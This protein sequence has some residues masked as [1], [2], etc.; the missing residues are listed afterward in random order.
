MPHTSQYYNITNS[1]GDFAPFNDATARA[2]GWEYYYDDPNGLSTKLGSIRHRDEGGVDILDGTF[3]IDAFVNPDLEHLNFNSV[4]DFRHGVKQV[5]ILNG[6]SIDAGKVYA[7]AVNAEAVAGYDAESGTLTATL[8]DGSGTP[9]VGGTLTGTLDTWNGLAGLTLS[10]DMLNDGQVDVMV[11]VVGTNDIPGYPTASTTN[12]FGSIVA[13]VLVHEVTLSEVS[14]PQAN[15]LNRD[16]VVN[17]LDADLSLSYLDGSIDGG[18]GAVTRQNMNIADGMTT[19]EAL[20]ALNLTEFDYDGNGFF[21]AADV[22]ALADNFPLRIENMAMSGSGHFEVD[23]V[24]MRPGTEYKLMK[25]TDL[26]NGSFDVEVDSVTTDAG[27]ATMVDT[28]AS[29]KAFYKVTD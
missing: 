19:N 2:T 15:D 25:A 10:G 13:K 18:D 16:G 28:N 12:N 21:D 14:V 17:I 29:G 22:I 23:V 8:T 9:I 20:T 11:D 3:Y 24:N 5:D 27:S 26:V 6:V 7:F 1:F 4:M